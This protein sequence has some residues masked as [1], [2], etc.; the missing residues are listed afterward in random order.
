MKIALFNPQGNFDN[1]DSYWTQHP[2]FGGQLVYVKELAKA[3]DQQGHEA[4]IFTRQITDPEWPEFAE[5]EETY[6]GTNAKIIRIPFGGEGFLEKEKLWPY[7]KD[8]VDGIE[9]WYTRQNFLPE[10][11]LTHYGDGGIA[12]AMFQEKTGIPY[13]F[14]GH[15]L[16]A[17][18]LDKL[19]KKPEDYDALDRQYQFS[20]RLTAERRA[21]E[22]AVIRFVST[23]QERDHQYQH[24]LYRDLFEGKE[25][26]KFRVVPPG[27]NQKLFSPEEGETDGKVK[28]IF[29]GCMQR[30]IAADRR[31]LP[32]VIASSRL[33]PKKNLKGLMEAYAGDPEWQEKSNLMIAVRGVENPFADYSSLKEEERE[34][35]DALFSIMEEAGLRGKVSF[36]NLSSQAALAAAYRKIASGAGVFTLT[37]LYEPF[38]LATIE[39]MACGLPVV[40]TANGGGQEILRPDG[41]PCGILADPEDPEAIAGGVKE[42]LTKKDKW[43]QCRENALHR[44]RTTYTWEAA[45]KAYTEAIEDHFASETSCASKTD[46]PEYFFEPTEENR[47]K[48]RKD[49]KEGLY[50]QE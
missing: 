36:I 4:V 35:M 33:E 11:V 17:Q 18:K 32:V 50:G 42:L 14:T 39:A 20:I 30:D 16:G 19:M 9:Q 25:E 29:E 26:R 5:P 44:V 37:S 2:D 10:V 34:Q 47:E 41:G 21:M 45:A 13:T 1:Q 31:G 49:R 3:L 38:G 40:V 43:S 46:I 8:Y 6:Q 28:G 7:L 15:S 27:V 24:P 48:L 23:A 22:G 12:G